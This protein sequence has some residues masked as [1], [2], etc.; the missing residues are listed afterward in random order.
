M[1]IVRQ[2]AAHV[3]TLT[4]D[5]PDRRNALSAALLGE[6]VAELSAA[7]QEGMRAVIVQASPA[8]GVWSAGHDI[9]ELPQGD[10]DPLTWDNP[11][12][13]ALRAVR[14]AP[15][16]VIAAVDGSVWGG[17]CD[18]VLTC[19]LVVAVR[20][21]SFAITPTRLGIPYNTGRRQPL[22]QCPA[23][24]CG[25]RRCSSPPIPSPPN[26]PPCTGS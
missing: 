18:L 17:A 20:T 11:L 22:R 23:L 13:E 1:P 8:G 25:P 3:L 10:R 2:D 16:P 21:A 15:F 5:E 26:R 7:A 24:A 6:F 12:E 4:L 9:D 19:D 14:D